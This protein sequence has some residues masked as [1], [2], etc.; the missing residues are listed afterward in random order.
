[1]RETAA[2]S[3]Y[4]VSD[5]IPKNMNTENELGVD[6]RDIETIHEIFSDG[7]PEIESDLPEGTRQILLVDSHHL[8]T[9]NWVD[10]TQSGK[11]SSATVVLLTGSN[12]PSSD[13]EL[14]KAY[15]T[16]IEDGGKVRTPKYVKARGA[17][18]LWVHQRQLENLL[19][20]IHEPSVYCWVGHFSGGH[21][22]GDVHTSHK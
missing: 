4:Q 3:D 5:V 19:V 21:I 9:A 14:S 18:Y 1:M 20:Q 15:V 16:V 22:Y 12:S 7:L 11:T 13:K 17:I 10:S 8:F 2:G 6:K